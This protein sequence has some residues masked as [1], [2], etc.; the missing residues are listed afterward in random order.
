MSDTHDA[1][2]Q[3]VDRKE[4]LAQQ[5]NEVEQ[6]IN[7]E[8]VQPAKVQ[9]AAGERA[10]DEQGKFA[11]KTTAAEPKI[12]NGKPPEQ[13]T[14]SIEEP[15][16]NK[17]PASWKKEKH[18]LWSSMTPEQR[19]Y[20]FQREEQMR[21]GV[22]PLLPKAQLADAISKVAEPYMNTIRG[23]GLDLPQAVEGLMRAD[24]QLR[25]LPHDQKLVYVQNLLR[26]YGIDISG[27]MQQAH[28][29][30]DPN[31]QHLRNEVL[32]VKGQFTSFIQ[33]QEAAQE[34][35]VL[36]EIQSFAKTAEHFEEATPAMIQLLQ[37]GM[38]DSIQEAYD[39]AIRLDPNLFETVQK[40][41]QATA[42]ATTRAAA[43]AAAKKAKAAAVS[44][45]SAT[46]GTQKPTNAQDRRSMLAEQIS[47]LSDRL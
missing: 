9:P 6:T 42:T 24:H 22:E 5:F 11:P 16:W 7:T 3:A 28:P 29:A 13:V 23:V 46:P 47:G 15:A 44:V 17:P 30:F 45:K 36:T 14:P 4:L 8:T 32:S 1:A 27:Q 19:E 25:T 40:A 33:Q 39:K 12:V 34:R 26:S 20:A 31:Y 35:A 43:D 38:A 41:Q 2:P 18:Q 10:R 37:G 21:S